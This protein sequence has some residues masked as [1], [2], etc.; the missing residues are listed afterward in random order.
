ML[1]K[2]DFEGV[3]NNIDSRRP[4]NAQVRFKN[5][6]LAIRLLPAG[7][8]SPTFSTASVKS[9]HCRDVRRMTALA[10]K[11]DFDLRSCDVADV[12]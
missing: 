10:P 2:K 11:A 8:P 6:S 4:A 9:G 3:L 12:P 5:S 7:A 1:L